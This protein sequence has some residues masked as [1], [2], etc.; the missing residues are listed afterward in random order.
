MTKRFLRVLGISA[1]LAAA[2]S[3]N[4]FAEEIT[5]VSFAAGCDTEASL[6]AGNTDPVFVVNDTNAEYELSSYSST[7]SSDSYKTA[8]TYELTFEA[9]SGYTFPSANSITVTGKG[10]TEITKKTVDSDTTLVVKVKAY[11]YHMWEAPQDIKTTENSSGKI[12]KISWDKNGAP[13]SEYILKYTNTN[14]ETKYLHGT[15]SSGSYSVPA[16]VRTTVTASQKE[17]NDK[18]DAEYEGFAVRVKGNAG[19]NPY[20]APSEWAGDTG[21]VDEYSDSELESYENWGDLFEGVST[22]G[23]S[24]SSKSASGS[25]NAGPGQTLNGW[26]GSNETWYYYKDGAAVKGW[27]NDG[28]NWYYLNPVTGLM[29]TGW[30]IDNSK[31]YYLNPNHGGP[32]G[33]MV[34]GTQTIDGQT[35]TFAASGEV[36]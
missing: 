5:S 12:T 35:Y 3:I 26:V 19:S 13:T 31:R 32:L 36:Q 34:T 2:F 27:Y 24:S 15:T 25:S 33:S 20:T 28:A 21:I 17:N 11:V 9:N 10:I 14:G 29:E 23:G 22:T 8:K 30:I 4:A 6:S 7:S 1:A 16:A 18:Q